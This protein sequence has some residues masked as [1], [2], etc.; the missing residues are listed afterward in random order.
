M[1]II[2][3]KMIDVYLD[4]GEKFDYRHL[5]VWPKSSSIYTHAQ[6]RIVVHYSDGTKFVYK[7]K[8]EL[9]NV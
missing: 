1:E 5:L 7:D 9:F 6:D 3:R 2:E 4:D 8:S